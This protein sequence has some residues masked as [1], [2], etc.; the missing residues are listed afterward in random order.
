MSKSENQKKKILLLIDY[1]KRNTDENHS[2]TMEQILDYLS[3]N[4][5]DAERKSIYDDIA[6]LR[7]YGFDIISERKHRNTYYSL[8]DRDFELSQVKILVDA[9]NSFK[10]TSEKNSKEIVS[11][12]G[13]LVSRYQ[14]SALN[15][16]T[17]VADRVKSNNKTIFFNIDQIHIA[18]AENSKISFN[19]FEWDFTK[20]KVYKHDKKTYIVSPFRM[21]L[22]DGN[23]YLIA[24]ENKLVK[25][26]RVD[27]ME[28]VNLIDQKREGSEYIEE[29][30]VEDYS[31]GVFGMFGNNFT[32][33]DLL[34]SNKMANV[35][36]DRFGQGI[37]MTKV[38]SE[39][40]KITQRIA[41][42]D[43]F[44]GWVFALGD[45][46]KILNPPEIAKEYQ[47]K[48]IKIKNMY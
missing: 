17:L 48:L 22:S 13:N 30:N 45:N 19:Y 8:I 36:I 40:F 29:K 32:K 35:V 47:D 21:V 11:K 5:V 1:F 26:F 25:H 34:F 4:G 6:V 2:V 41:I 38:D 16:Q 43:Q 42:S 39:H 18:I 20:K 15:R 3:Q 28:N 7:D 46:V 23:Y 27:K 44:Y 37:I 9:V 31:Q 10:F 12:L 14:S 24:V 33:V